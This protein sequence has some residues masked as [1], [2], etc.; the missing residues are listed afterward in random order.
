VGIAEA[1]AEVA[2]FLEARGQ[3][4]RARSHAV[5]R[6]PGGSPS[7]ALME[8]PP[9][10]VGAPGAVCLVAAEGKG[11]AMAGEGRTGPRV[12][13]WIVGAC[14]LPVVALM[15][16]V[17]A[18]AA[19]SCT[20]AGGTNTASVTLDAGGDSATISVGPGNAIQ[21]NGSN[22][23]AATTGNTDVVEVTG[24][25]DGNQSVTISQTGSGGAF[26]DAMEFRVDLAGGSGD[27]LTIVGTGGND[28]IAFGTNGITIDGDNAAD[29]IDQTG[30]AGV[31]AGVESFAAKGGAGNDTLSG[32]GPGAAFGPRLALDGEA[33]NDTVEGGNG[34][35]ALEGGDGDD[36]LRGGGGGDTLTGGAGNDGIDGEAGTD[37]VSYE[38]AVPPGV[39]VDLSVTTAQNTGGGGSDAIS[40]VEN[41][42][43]SSGNDTLRGSSGPNVLLGSLGNDVLEGRDGNDQLIGEEG[44]DALAGGGGDDRLDG[45]DG[46]DTAS[47]V[48]SGSGVSVNL[49]AGT[50]SGEGSDTLAAIENVRGSD[51]GD[52]LVGNDGG[53]VLTGRGGDDGV[54]GAGGEDALRG[55]PG[56][57]RLRAGTGAD[58]LRGGTGNDALRAGEGND[59][60]GGGGGDDLLAGGPGRDTCR[61]GPGAD[62]ERS[63]ER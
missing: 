53:N 15:A 29:V 46:V 10:N 25:D 5:G 58:S 57:D 12:R 11:V 43:G 62:T 59:V 17:P 16:V 44:N 24:D 41:V 49:A 39:T 34:D 51:H 22:C 30:A 13:I 35:D 26:P 54:T 38:G 52:T 50:A 6:N 9:G 31:P 20:Y 61:G 2:G 55:G 23:E 37:T 28:T 4:R 45:G 63:C 14:V 36:T 8:V 42:V 32:D 56:A 7:L 21:V 19:V 1:A 48:A 27:A 18:G 60:V 3:S 33:G 40:N 47:F